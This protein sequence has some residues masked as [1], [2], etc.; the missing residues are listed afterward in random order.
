MRTELKELAES[1]A[2]LKQRE[3]RKIA[4]L[5]VEGDRSIDADC[6]IRILRIL[7]ISKL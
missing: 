5:K 3:M 6:P 4:Q 7:K 2:D 1:E